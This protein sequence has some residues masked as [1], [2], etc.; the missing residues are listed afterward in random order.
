MSVV[1]A[2]FWRM[3]A[4]T[5]R[6]YP[7]T[8]FTSTVLTGA[9]TIVLAYLAYK[10]VG[11]GEVDSAFTS[12]TGS[13]DYVG[14]VAVGAITYTF[15]VRMLLWTAKALITEERE[16]TIAALVVAPAGRMPYLLGFGAFAVLSTLAET[17]ALA[18]VAGFLNVT[19]PVPHAAGLVL[20]LAVFTLALFAMSLVLSSVML[21]AG[22]AHISQNTLF[23]G[24]GLL[25]GFTF[26][27]EYLP[28][29]AQWLAEFL[30]VTAALDGLRAAL[31]GDF[32]YATAMP[33]LGVAAVVSACYLALGRWLLPRAE[34]RA[35]ERT[36]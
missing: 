16:G 17:G 13:S 23:L 14:Y 28:E 5:R 22:E 6:A 10:A 21:F 31:S 33:R 1:L 20:S 25:C 19:L 9:L 29:A 8:Y 15:A 3:W 4:L 12:A 34:Q 11:G 18:V 30:P 36:F 35:L 7:W 26:P 32:D 27:R 2:T 24:M